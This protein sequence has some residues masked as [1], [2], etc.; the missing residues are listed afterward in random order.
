MREGIHERIQA[1]IHQEV[2]EEAFQVEERLN[3]PPAWNEVED[4]MME[5]G[6]IL[7]ENTRPK[8]RRKEEISWGRRKRRKEDDMGAETQEHSPSVLKR[9]RNP[10]GFY[11]KNWDDEQQEED[12]WQ[13]PD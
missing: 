4:L 1:E 11:F 2:S 3:A 9:T 13:V 5:D 7:E 12:E 10:E 6:E 8:K